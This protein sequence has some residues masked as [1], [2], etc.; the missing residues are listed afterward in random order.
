MYQPSINFISGKIILDNILHKCF[1][2]QAYFG[3]I[4]LD[5]PSCFIVYS[6]FSHLT[7][8][9]CNIAPQMCFSCYMANIALFFPL[10]FPRKVLYIYICIYVYV[11]TQL[12]IYYYHH[13][14]YYLVSSQPCWYVQSLDNTTTYNTLKLD[15]SHKCDCNWLCHLATFYQISTIY[16]IPE[17]VSYIAITQYS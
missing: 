10:M 2:E 14:Y 15:H 1:S 3:S 4:N 9:Y 17:I 13:Y 5:M 8:L 12:V 6:M 11:C 7:V 16:R